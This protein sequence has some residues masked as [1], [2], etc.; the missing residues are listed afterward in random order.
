MMNV[1]QDCEDPGNG[2]NGGATP[3]YLDNMRFLNNP[4][5]SVRV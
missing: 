1:S 4:R 2:G 3:S 5:C